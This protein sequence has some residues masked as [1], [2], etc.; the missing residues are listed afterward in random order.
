MNWY[1]RGTQIF[2]IFLALFLESDKI[3]KSDEFPEKTIIIHLRCILEIKS[4]KKCG[5]KSWNLKIWRK[6]R[7]SVKNPDTGWISG[8][9]PSSHIWEVYESICEEISSKPLQ[10]EYLKR[11]RMIMKKSKSITLDLSITSKKHNNFRIKAKFW[12]SF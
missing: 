5:L 3:I 9:M 6:C 10:Y 12:W 11:I 1:L 8:M 7:K 2:G 4:W